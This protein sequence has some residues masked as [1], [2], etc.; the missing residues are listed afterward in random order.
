MNSPD[1]ISLQWTTVQYNVFELVGQTAAF[2]GYTVL[3]FLSSRMFIKRGIKTRLNRTLLAG[4]LFMYLLSTAYFAYTVVNVADRM[5]IFLDV[6]LNKSIG[7]R[8]SFHDNITKWSPLFNAVVLVNYVFSDAVVIWRSWIITPV[9]HRRWIAIPVTLVFLAS[10]SVISTIV[11]RAIAFV[12]YPLVPVPKDTFID[13]GIN[14]LQLLSIGLSLLSNISATFVVGIVAIQHRQTISAAFIT[15]KHTR[16]T[17]G[18]RILRLLVESGLLYCISGLVLAVFCFIRLPHGTL[19]DIYTPVTVHI[20]G[21]YP[22]IVF[23][24]IKEEMSLDKTEFT[25]VLPT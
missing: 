6:A 20:S 23:L 13:R 5:N 24:L 2:G 14:V 17:R 16:L 22:L 4:S 18:E 19:G 21:A 1:Y 8:G 15:A 12:Q 25:L 3:I 9:Q 10:V 7:L 11:F